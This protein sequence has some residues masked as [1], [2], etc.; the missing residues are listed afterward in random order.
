MQLTKEMKKEH[1]KGLKFGN[2]ESFDDGNYDVIMYVEDYSGILSLVN[3]EEDKDLEKNK[4]EYYQTGEITPTLVLWITDR[5][6][7][8]EG[9][10][11]MLYIPE[12][13]FDATI[14]FPEDDKQKIVRYLLEQKV[15]DQEGNALRHY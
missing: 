5:N 11:F 6:I 9:I 2:L 8:P 14:N 4:Q 1:L 10:D 12:Y 3:F 15:L 7:K 13:G